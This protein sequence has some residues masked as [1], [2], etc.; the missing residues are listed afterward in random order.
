MT[1]P[2]RFSTIRVTPVACSRVATT[3]TVS[4]VIACSR[5]SAETTRPSALE[6]TLLVSD[7]DV[8]VDQRVVAEQLG[9]QLHEVVAGRDLGQPVG[10]PDLEAR[11]HRTSLGSTSAP[12]VSI[13]S[14]WLRPTLCR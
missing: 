6:T 12:N 4:S 2:S 5:S 7:E 10:R 13:H 14:R 9:E 11:A 3:R 8:T 1:S